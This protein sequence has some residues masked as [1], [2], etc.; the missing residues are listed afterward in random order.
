MNNKSKGEIMKAKEQTTYP[1]CYLYVQEERSGESWVME[2]GMEEPLDLRGL[3]ERWVKE[4]YGTELELDGKIMP[5]LSGDYYAR[6][7]TDGRPPE[8]VVCW[9]GGGFYLKHA[10]E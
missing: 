10:G 5:K 1:E 8:S 2:I 6:I 4:Q 3:I 7:M 9:Q